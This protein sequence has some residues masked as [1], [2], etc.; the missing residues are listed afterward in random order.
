MEWWQR[1]RGQDPEGSIAGKQYRVIKALYSIDGKR[2]ADICK[3]R[4]GKTYL[5]ESDWVEGTTFAPRHEGRMVGP[6]DSP[7]AAERFI[8]G[9]DWFCGRT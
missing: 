7:L 2:R 6:F 5:L 8:V 1:L 4:W 3:F 9:T